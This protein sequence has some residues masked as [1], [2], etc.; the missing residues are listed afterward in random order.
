[1]NVLITGA[2][3][4]IGYA[5][6]KEFSRNGNSRLFL[7]SRSESGLNNLREACQKINANVEIVTIPFDIV[8]LEQEELPE[9][10]KEVHLDIL[11]NN[12]GLLINKP[13]ED[14]SAADILR[15]IQTNLL[16]PALLIRKSLVNLGGTSHSHIVNIGSM[17]GF[18]GSV[19]FK[20]LSMYSA[21]KAALASMTECLAEEL[22]AQNI[23]VN[24]LAL[25]SV[26]TEMLEE[27]FPGYQ[28][29]V[30]SEEMAAF[31]ADFAMNGHRFF[32]GKVLPVSASTP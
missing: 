11:I 25:G 1:M 14:L 21:S 28:A 30:T 10:I 15:M 18:Q 9:V 20:G 17:G 13:F 23:V 12:A 4:G 5:L 26:Q 16:A 22:K 19:K 7:M 3:R 2:S 24:C 31:I 32:N 8:Q 29:P 6:A 27:A